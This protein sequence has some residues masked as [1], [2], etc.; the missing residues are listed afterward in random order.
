MAGSVIV[1][2]L[3]NR[4]SVADSQQT[5]RMSVLF[6]LARFAWSFNLAPPAAFSV[7]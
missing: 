2:F 7:R 6:P 4:Q 5:A 1:K 3:P